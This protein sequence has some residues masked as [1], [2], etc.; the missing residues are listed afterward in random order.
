MRTIKKRLKLNKQQ[1]Q[2]VSNLCK[3][4][5]NL[6]NYS[7]YVCNSYYKETNKYI[8]V[9]SLYKEVK[10]NENFKLLPSQSSR[11]IIR[12]VDKNYRSFFSLLNRKSKGQYTGDVSPPNYRKKGAMFNLMYTWQNIK[13]D[14]ESSLRTFGSNYYY[15]KHGIKP[16]LKFS[17]TY[18]KID[19]IK[20]IIIKS[21]NNGQY[22]KMFIQYEEKK[23]ERNYDLDKNK[24][25]GIDLGINNL[26]S[27]FIPSG[28]SLLV[29]GKSLKSYNRWYNKSKAKLQ[30]ELKLKQNKRWSKKLQL[31]EEKRYNWIDNYFNQSVSQIIGYC[32]TNSVGNIIIGYN[33]TWKKK[34]NIGKVNNQKFCSIPHAIFKQ[35]LENKCN[36]FGITF[37][38]TEESYTSK[39]NFL[40]G[41]DMKRGIEFTGKRIKRGLY[42][43]TDGTLI[44]SDINGAANIIRKVIP[45]VHKNQGIVGLM[46]NP[47]KLHV[48]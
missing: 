21:Y 34:S 46:L 17:F 39:A 42:Q 8:G 45:D 47:L 4:S 13:W 40:N 27:C 9:N 19:K 48:L 15:E 33:K 25:M 23:E 36:E 10:E 28:P 18:D 41:D 1:Y 35:K 24:Y 3:Y 44:N 43:T 14:N 32:L 30:S 29:N 12:L 16:I 38:F 37:Q 20:Q 2:I 7:L 11:L 6:Y 5:N 31:L 26:A 22:F